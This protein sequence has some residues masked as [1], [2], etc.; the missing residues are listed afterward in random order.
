M[1][2]ELPVIAIGLVLATI[3]FVALLVARRALIQ[4][5][6][7]RQERIEEKVRPIA[8]AF[9]F[10]D[11]QIPDHGLSPR[12]SD[13]LATVLGRYARLLSGQS[14]RLIASYFERFG[15]VDRA[16][17]E[18][19][20]ARAWRRATA[21]KRL[22]DMGSAR[23]V[24]PLIACLEDRSGEVRSVAAES[25]GRLEAAAA[26]GP[27]LAAV[28]D[29]RIA[30]PTAGRALLRIGSGATPE[31][32]AAAQ[33]DDPKIRRL[34]IELLVHVG[35]SAEAPLLADSLADSSH[36]VRAKASRGLGRLA[37]NG[38]VRQVRMMLA[39]AV[40]SV[41]AAA[42]SG[43]GAI[44]DRDSIA[45]LEYVAAG[46]REFAPARA[47]ARALTEID[48]RRVIEADARGAGPHI[49]EAADRIRNGLA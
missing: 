10:G 49:R 28:R 4:A 33:S 39:D 12:E 23:A 1:T 31:L 42:A 2:A 13:A 18:L 19:R 43:L 22:G 46:E 41:R 27:I 25:L 40:P 5:R 37:S 26:A 34:A 35:S 44:G 32:F 3:P 45:L 11:S 16:L 38:E 36:D 6:L 24:K 21:A 8:T 20:S 17:R 30:R 9:V 48:P 15:G 7:N 14:R 29:D 47:A